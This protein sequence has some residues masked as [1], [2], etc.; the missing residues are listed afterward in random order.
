VLFFKK[1]HALPS[2]FRHEAGMALDADLLID[3]RRLKRRLNF[4]RV[5]AIVALVAVALLALPLHGGRNGAFGQRIARYRING[6]IGDGHEQIEALN[7]MRDD[8]GVAAVLLH[9]DTPGGDVAGGEGMHAAVEQL[10]ARKPV[11]AVMDGTAAS[12][13]YMIAVATPHI[14]ARESTITGSIGVIMELG[15]IEGM[16]GKLGI[17]ADQLVS[18]P[19]KGQPSFT[20][21][22]SPEGRDVLQGLVGDLFD[23]FVG[24]VAR[25]RHMDEDAVRKLADGRAYTG[26]Q[27]KALGLVDEIGGEAEA[28]VWL[29]KTRHLSVDLPVRDEDKD[30]SP[31]HMLRSSM[32]GL[33][34]SAVRD[35][36]SSARDSLRIDGAYA[37]WQPSGS[38]D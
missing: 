28:L 33:L 34:Q 32:D 5:L 11:V 29:Q 13:G 2:V 7:D 35:V 25:G 3:R 27:A 24:M 9:L 17:R 23:Q 6:M 12:A 14:V 18:G 22:L 37:V 36:V 8:S 1:E 21:P 4:W 26:R 15:D 38:R 31:L 16:L 20:K 19:L 10:A 30:G